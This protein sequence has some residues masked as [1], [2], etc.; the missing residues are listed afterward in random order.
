MTSHW[1]RCRALLGMAYGIMT[2]ALNFGSFIYPLLAPSLGSTRS[3]EWGLFMLGVLATTCA[4]TILTVGAVWYKSPLE[5]TI[6]AQAPE[7]SKT[8]SPFPT[9]TKEDLVVV[10]MQQSNSA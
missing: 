1:L 6:I 10:E 8:P 5:L 3:A 2:C 9:T 7:P 4:M